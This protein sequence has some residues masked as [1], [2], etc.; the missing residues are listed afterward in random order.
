MGT[1][2]VLGDIKDMQ[3][4]FGVFVLDQEPLMS[5]KGVR[6]STI[7]SISINL[8]KNRKSQSIPLAGNWGNLRSS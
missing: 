1:L 2:Y 3:G 7:P 8:S 5:T 6:F 4:T